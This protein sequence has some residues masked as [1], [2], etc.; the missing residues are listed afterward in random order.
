MATKIPQ[1][2]DPLVFTPQ[3]ATEY[4][5]LTERQIY[6]AVRKKRITYVRVGQNIRF[7]QSDLDEY[8]ERNT[9]RA[10]DP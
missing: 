7:R 10:T 1:N 8:I 5:P 9:V 6:D 4:L 3:T 2:A